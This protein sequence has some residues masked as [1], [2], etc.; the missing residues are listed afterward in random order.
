MKPFFS[1]V[2]PTLNEE[3]YLPKLLTCL[4][5]Q[6]YR[7]F[8]VIIV[9]GNSKDSTILKADSFKNK[10]PDLKI[11]NLTKA[12]VAKQ[13]NIGAEKSSGEYIIFFDADS[14]ITK[15][16]LKLIYKRITE[17]KSLLIT[18]WYKPDSNNYHD[19]VM[20]AVGNIGMEAANKT[21]RPFVGGTNIVVNRYIFKHVGGFNP[22]LF[23][24]EDHDFVQRCRDAGLIIDIIKNPRVTVSLRR[25]RK[26]GYFSIIRKYATS[27]IY[28]ILKKPVTKAIFDYPMGGDVYQ[29][30]GKSKESL[31]HEIENKIWTSLK[32]VLNSI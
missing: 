11:I 4:A 28:Q 9:D 30:S 31:L 8:E 32:S 17:G 24:S 5:K 18:S 15:N 14:E 29:K 7:D 22:T 25:F 12:N 2:I 13:R 10:V 16:Y 6:T 21:G 19:I 20:T 3:I 1:I 23:Q 27:S 26:F